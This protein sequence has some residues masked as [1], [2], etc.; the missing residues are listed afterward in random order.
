MST[1]NPDKI[2]LTGQLA[3]KELS[4]LHYGI[5]HAGRLNQLLQTQVE[6]E[7]QSR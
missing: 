5:G 6:R 1:Q 4:S 7:S 3:V 2:M